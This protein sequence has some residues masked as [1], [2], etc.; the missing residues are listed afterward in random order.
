MYQPY[1]DILKRLGAPLWWDENGVPRYED[2]APRDCANIYAEFAALLEIRC[3]G[4]DRLFPVASTWGISDA[5]IANR[6]DDVVWD[7]EG[8][9]PTPKHGLPKEGSAGAF[10]Y[11]DAPWHDYDGGFNGQCAGTTMTTATVRVL[12]FWDKRSYDLKRLPECE[13]YVGEDKE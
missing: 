3:Q 1:I 5:I 2:F 6:L 13:V 8:K 7:A 10:G 12:Q 11:G 4:C 9:N